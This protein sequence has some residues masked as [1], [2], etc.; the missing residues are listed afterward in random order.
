MTP[1][2]YLS[3]TLTY[4]NRP[5]EL[6]ESLQDE[7]TAL[8]RRMHELVEENGALRQQIAELAELVRTKDELISAF[9]DCRELIHTQE[10]E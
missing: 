4:D 3:T 2:R 8:R 7:I 10:R 9:N 6:C 1:R 5:L